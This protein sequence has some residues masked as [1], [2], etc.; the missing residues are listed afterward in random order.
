[1]LAGINHR[2]NAN[3]YAE[4]I[5]SGNQD[6]TGNLA[7]LVTSVSIEK[8]RSSGNPN[9]VFLSW[10]PP[11]DQTLDVDVYEVRKY[12]ETNAAHALK[13]LLCLSRKHTNPTELM[14]GQTF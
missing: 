6:P 5:V 3:N 10:Q 14:I 11:T 12:S 2:N 7:H 4:V 9:A 8:A 13:V 1:M